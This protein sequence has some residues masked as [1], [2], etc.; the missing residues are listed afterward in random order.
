MHKT[1]LINSS[2]AT[3]VSNHKSE[4]VCMNSQAIQKHVLQ[5][6]RDYAETSR[7]MT[8]QHHASPLKVSLIPEA[9]P[10]KIALLFC[11]NNI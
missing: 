6:N 2:M 10:S 4:Q 9:S 1:T 8:S 7:R 5:V 11:C 3:I